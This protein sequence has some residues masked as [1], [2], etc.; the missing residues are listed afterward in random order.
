MVSYL[1]NAELICMTIGIS[2][3]DF[4]NR[5]IPNWMT[6]IL[7]VS[8]VILNT[9]MLGFHGLL[10]SILGMT[11][12]AT[13]LILWWLGMLGAGDVKL[14]MAIGSCLGW[15]NWITAFI[16]SIW[17]GGIA[18]AIIMLI[19]RNCKERM[20]YL[21]N[22]FKLMLYTGTIQKYGDPTQYNKEHFCFSGCIAAGVIVTLF[23]TK[24]GINII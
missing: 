19:R 6:V 11:I 13:N 22:Y 5:K 7:L 10:L 15:K 2:V 4:R 3:L 16:L 18:S 17:I 12:G 8:G 23:L 14:Y 9:I 24:K 20:T 21:L 1:L